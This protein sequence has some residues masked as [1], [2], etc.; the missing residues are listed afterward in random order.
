M[1]SFSNTERSLFLRFVWG[2][3]RLPRTIADFRGRD[4]VIQV[5]CVRWGVGILFDIATCGREVAWLLW[6]DPGRQL[7][8]TQPLACSSPAGGLVGR[9][10]ERQK[11]LWQLLGWDRP[12]NKLLVDEGEEGK[13]LKKSRTSHHHLTD[14]QLA[15]E[16]WQPQQTFPLIFYCWSWCHMVSW[17]QLSCLCSLPPCALPASLLAGQPE[18]QKKTLTPCKHC[19]ARTKTLVC[20]QHCFHHESR[21]QQSTGHCEENWLY[22]PKPVQWYNRRTGQFY[23]WCEIVLL[24]RQ[25]SEDVK[26]LCF[27]LFQLN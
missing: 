1:E 16:Q 9:E 22:Q 8:T 3:T 17:D 7:S 12:F 15:P 23:Y 21:T 13:K 19:S 2:R 27:F 11:K 6:S 18:Q 20:Y 10:S 25:F 14:A 26:H 5:R 24:I 4:F